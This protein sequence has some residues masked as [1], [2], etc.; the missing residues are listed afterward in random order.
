MY[1]DARE[2]NNGIC[3]DISSVD[4]DISTIDGFV[5]SIMVGRY[6]VSSPENTFNFH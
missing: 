5:L 3:F 1:R 4:I 2:G 6:T